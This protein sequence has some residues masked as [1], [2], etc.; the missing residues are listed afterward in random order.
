MPPSD[1][2]LLAALLSLPRSYRRALL[3]YDGVGLDLP[4]TAAEVEASTPAT[5]GRLV[6]ARQALVARLP[7]L[8]RV[9]R[10]RLGAV[11]HQ[12]LGALA[13]TQPV[14]LRTAELVRG[15]SERT[16]RLLVRGGVG[17]T[18][19]IAAATAFTLATASAPEAPATGPP[20]P[21]A[22]TQ[23]P[24]SPRPASPAPA[25][26]PATAPQGTPPEGAI[27]E[28]APSEGTSSS[29]EAPSGGASSDGGVGH[30]DGRGGAPV[31]GWVRPP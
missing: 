26:P 9:P 1:P 5:A 28:E 17:L 8:R 4:E 3:L 2:A 30:D 27:P 6:H 16:T 12:R 7:E 21:A 19:L 25:S 14:E 24:A 15:G 18:A 20:R 29:E 22:T 31:G 23:G 10:D 13:V 11:L